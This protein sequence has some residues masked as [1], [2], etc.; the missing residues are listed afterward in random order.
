MVLV[1]GV[2]HSVDSSEFAFRQAAIGAMRQAFPQ[3]TPTILEPV[4]SVEV[5]APT[6]FQVCV[7]V[8]VCVCACVCVCVC[9]CVYVC[10]CVCVCVLACV[11]VR[12]CVCACVCQ[13]CNASLPI[14]RE[15]SLQVLTRD[16]VSSQGQMRQ[17]AISLSTVRYML[18][19][20]IYHVYTLTKYVCTLYRRV[21]TCTC[22]LCFCIVHS[23]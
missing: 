14:Y 11:C 16:V 1:D 7:C 3:A 5:V 12:A 17:K 19:E 15:Q 23:I 18:H 2:S 21:Y 20:C 22:M 6:E 13:L 4:M 10:V 8:C 9:V